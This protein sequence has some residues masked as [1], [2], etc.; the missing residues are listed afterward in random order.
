[1]DGNETELVPRHLCNGRVAY[2]PAAGPGGFLAIWYS[3]SR[4]L[5]RL[6]RYETG[7][8]TLIDLGASWSFRWGRLSLVGHN[9]GDSRHPV[10]DSEVGDGQLYISPPRRFTAEVTFRF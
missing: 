4:F 7:S 5:D 1:M 2:S 10:T 8:S 3:G 6:N 9:L